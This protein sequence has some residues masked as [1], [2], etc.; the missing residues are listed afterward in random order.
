MDITPD[1]KT[2]FVGIQHPGEV[3]SGSFNLANPATYQSHW[4]LGGTGSS[5]TADAASGTGRPRSAVVMVTKN[6]GGIIG[7]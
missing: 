1:G 4:P 6:D 5:A 7:M 2:M 3:V